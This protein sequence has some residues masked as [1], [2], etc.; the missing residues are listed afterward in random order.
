MDTLVSFDDLV[1]EMH[2]VLR[3]GGY[4]LVTLPNLA[5]WHNRIALLLGF[6]PRDVE[7]SSEILPG[8][9]PGYAD[10]SPAGHIHVPTLRAFL[11]L[12][13]YHGF[14]KA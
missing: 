11:D 6:Q 2:R 5:S 10:E 12:M 13:R 7:I 3:P 14:E 1:R 8:V 4:L 9:V